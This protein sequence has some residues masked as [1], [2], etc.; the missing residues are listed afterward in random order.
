MVIFIK[1]YV[2]TASSYADG[3]KIYKLIYPQ[4]AKSERVAVSFEGIDS[5]PSAFINSAFVRLLE[6]FTFD[7]IKNYLQ[8]INSTHHINTLIRDRFAFAVKRSETA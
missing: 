6:S 2:T 1:N 5:V 4:I 3:E 8:I 7:H